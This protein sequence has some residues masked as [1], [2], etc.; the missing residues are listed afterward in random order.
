MCGRYILIAKKKIKEVFNIEI[1]PNYNIAPSMPVLVFDEKLE[2]HFMKWGI[3][4][5]IKG[6]KINIFN[7]R[8]E[9]FKNS[10]IYYKINTCVFISNGYYE[11]KNTDNIKIPYFLYFKKKMMLFAGIYNNSGCSIVTKESDKKISHIHKRQPI[12]LDKKEIALWLEKKHNF[13]ST[14]S[15]DI[16]YHMV[17][18]NVNNIKNNLENNIENTSKK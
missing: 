12:I 18:K 5:E 8:S 13:S 9:N 7:S 6:K 15:K 10:N 2:A 3:K 16:N 17:S 14:I 4:K 11:W 1:V